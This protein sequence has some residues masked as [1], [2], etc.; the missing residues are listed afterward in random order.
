M[1]KSLEPRYAVEE[2]GFSSGDDYPVSDI[3][4]PVRLSNEPVRIDG[5]VWLSN[6]LVRVVKKQQRLHIFEVFFVLV[7]EVFVPISAISQT[8]NGLVSGWHF[9]APCSLAYTTSMHRVNTNQIRFQFN[10]LKHWK[11]TINIGVQLKIEENTPPLS[12]FLVWTC[13]ML[14]QKKKDSRSFTKPFSDE[15]S[16]NNQVA[17]FVDNVNC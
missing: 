17:H 16:V 6:E 9:S 5:A 2:L 1:L 12:I 7:S 11:W 14:W 13:A 8:G 3:D 10:L 15:L 4:D